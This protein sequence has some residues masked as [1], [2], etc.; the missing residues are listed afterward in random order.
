MSTGS[1]SPAAGVSRPMTSPR[2]CPGRN[3]LSAA[4]RRLLHG[5]HRLLHFG[6]VNRFELKA[7]SHF[8]GS[9]QFPIADFDRSLSPRPEDGLRRGG[10][11]KVQSDL[12]FSRQGIVARMCKMSPRS[13]NAVIYRKLQPYGPIEGDGDLAIRGVLTI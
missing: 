5:N 8:R 1:K 13:N 4:S 9:A 3:G 12:V 10:C 7:I 6:V 2:R 11:L